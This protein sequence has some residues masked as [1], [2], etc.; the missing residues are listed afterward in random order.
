MA[1]SNECHSEALDAVSVV[2]LPGFWKQ[3]PQ[4]WFTHAESVFANHR[5]GSRIQRVNHVVGALDE[6]GVRTI[7]D[8]LDND[9]TYEGIKNRLIEAYDLPRST[10][11][12][13]IIRPGCIGDR[14]PSQ[15]LRDMRIAL[16][17]EIGEEA[18]RQFWLQ[19]LP[20]SVL[21][22][23][24][25][26]DGPLD[27]LATRADR[28][29][30][31]I[32][33]DMEALE[34]THGRINELANSVAQL[35]VQ[36]ATLTRMLQANNARRRSPEKHTSSPPPPISTDT[37]VCYY[38]KTYGKSARN[39]RSPCSS[40]VASSRGRSQGHPQ[41]LPDPRSSAEN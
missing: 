13:D 16:P 39:C 12:R 9:V 26:L 37:G 32:P 11:F 28:V 31:A 18:L 17:A 41:P 4:Y 3:S 5:I 24:A 29:L 23:V 6:E 1:E 25:G 7:G 20:A 10:R 36:M 38:H 19:K 2:K 21:P 35:S 30:E 22:V 27:M 40:R 8:L 34:I 15:L 14:R 33:Q